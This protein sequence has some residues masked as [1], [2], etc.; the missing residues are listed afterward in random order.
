MLVTDRLIGRIGKTQIEFGGLAQVF[1]IPKGTP[2]M[3]GWSNRQK[4]KDAA[5]MMLLDICNET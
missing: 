4:T 2:S 1:P 3:L 5:M